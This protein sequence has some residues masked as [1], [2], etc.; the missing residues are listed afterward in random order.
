M[1]PPSQPRN[2][3]GGAG[4]ASHAVSAALAPAR[5]AAQAQWARLAPRER[6]LVRVAALLVAVA[7][8]WFVAIAPAWRTLRELPPQRAALEAQLQQ[9]Q[10]QAREAQ[11]LRAVA[12]VPAEQAQAALEA[13]AQRL[14]PQARLVAQGAQR[15]VLTLQGADGAQ[16]A[17]FLG[18]ARAGARARVLEAT[19]SQ[20]APGRYDGNLILAVGA[21]P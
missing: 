20:S 17:A 13:A 21:A 9:M 16:L 18:E 5:A 11:A 4:A 6:Q 15:S 10:A 7:L 14:G 8:L 19:L 1:S 2:A 3:A 12:P